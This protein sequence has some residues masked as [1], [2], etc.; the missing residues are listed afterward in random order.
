MSGTIHR[1][2]RPLAKVAERSGWTI[3]VSKTCHLKW[4][5]PMGRL[6]TVSA[7]TPSDPRS[8]KHLRTELR[9]AGLAV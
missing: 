7:G 5:D 3:E 9:R 4:R 2:F 6:V 1:D 8:V